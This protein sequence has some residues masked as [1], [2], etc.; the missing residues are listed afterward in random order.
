[1]LMLPIMP[2]ACTVQAAQS[3]QNELV[4]LLSMFHRCSTSTMGVTTLVLFLIL[5]A[6]CN[7]HS[8]ERV[9]YVDSSSHT[10]IDHSSCWEGGYSTPCLSLNLALKGAQHY[11]HSITILLQPGQH[12]LHNGSETQ[13]RNMSLLAIVGDTSSEGEV[14][15]KCQP[16][17]G[18]L[19]FR[20]NSIT[21]KN[22][23]MVCCGAL[24]NSIIKHSEDKMQSGV[25]VDTCNNIQLINV[26]VID[27]NGTGIVLYNPSGVVHLDMCNFINNSLSSV[28]PPAIGGGGLVIEADDVTTIFNC[29]I[30]NSNFTN[31]TY[32]AKNCQS[33]SPSEYL[34]L[35]GGISLLFKGG[36]ATNIITF[37]ELWL[38]NNMA[39]FGGGLFLVFY[40]SSSS[41]TVAVDNLMMIDNT[42][43]LEV[44]VLLPFASGGGIFLDFAASQVDYPYNNKIEI[45]NVKFLSNTAQLGGGIAVDV[46]YD[47]YGCVNAD[48]KLLIEN[49]SFDNNEGYQGASAYFSGTSKDCQ[50]LLNITISF[51]NFT[52]GNCSVHVLHTLPCLGSVLL[53]HFPLTLNGNSF[54]SG[55]AQ[56]AL[57]LTSSSIELI[58]SAQLQFTNNSGFNGAALHIADCS[59][60]IVNDNTS[61]YFENNQATHHG[62]A[63]Y[64]EACTQTKACFVRHSNS[65]LDPDQWKAKFTFINNQ[66]NI[67]GNSIYI[68]SVQSCVWPKYSKNVTFCWNEWQ[69][70]SHLDQLGSGPASITNN[71]PTKH[72]VYPGECINLHGFTVFDDFD[73]NITAQTNLQV[74]ILSGSSYAVSYNEPDCKCI[75]SIPPGSCYSMLNYTNRPCEHGEVAIRSDCEIDYASHGSQILIHPPHQSYGIVLDL[76]YKACDNGST[77]VN[78]SDYPGLCFKSSSP[79]LSYEGVCNKTININTFSR[80]CYSR[81][82]CGSCVAD[83]DHDV[84]MTINVPMFTCV[85]CENASG[86]GYFLIQILL[87][88]IMMTIL[89]VLHINITNG[90]LNAYILYSQMVTLQF[91]GLE[92]TAW[93]RTVDIICFTFLLD[94]YKYITI[95]LTVYSIW[96]INFLTF[97]PDSFC[98][99]GIRT[100]VGVILLQYVTAACPL[101]FIIVSYTWI[102]CYN[103]GYRL[104]VYTTG[105]VHRLLAR[106]WQKF[107]IKPSLIDTYAG[108][109]L[110][111]YMRFLAGSVKLLMLITFDS[112]F[113]SSQVAP[114]PLVIIPILCL[115]VFVILPMVVLLLYP[116]KIF[117]RCLTCCRLD[118]PGLHALVD[119]YQGCFKNSATDGT[120]RRYFAGFYLLFRFSYIAVVLVFS[121]SIAHSLTQQDQL[122]VMVLPLSGASLSFVMAGL[123]LILRPYKKTIHNIIDFLTLFLMTMFAALSAAWIS[124][125][126]IFSSI[127]ITFCFSLFYLPFLCLVV[128]LIYHMLICCGCCACVTQNAFRKSSHNPSKSSEQQPLLVPPT[129]HTVVGLGDY[130]EDDDYPDRMVHPD[131]YI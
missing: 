13:L 50:A 121:I 33:V 23:K 97:F 52:N 103:N 4:T 108:L 28:D 109:L 89:A 27:S 30:T 41:N 122:F 117:Q 84:G 62:G 31:N 87:V 101:L 113:A 46:V 40:D 12:Q 76:H 73:N 128:Y 22:L 80:F 47:G 100:A 7:V 37:S 130:A 125:S 116:F 88:M 60:V 96:N 51:S 49:C 106:F 19:F 53:N 24:H 110:L 71:G 70:D 129:T 114:V 102:Q 67:L 48:N 124:S 17:A 131:G 8:T 34:G 42:A 85:S 78:N 68:D 115:L 98:I 120:E 2:S 86:V 123:V 9:I 92:Y 79:I 20:S 90:N 39:P 36:S 81:I 10:G 94:G 56:S 82:K 16:L 1:M 32:T 63:I 58:P 29:S 57:G 69:Y 83:D 25:F 105:P 111:A 45:S 44:G 18:L 91:P 35:G 26:D 107:K 119:A 66:A 61:L 127:F 14:V 64:S 21:M 11:N 104:V 95:P 59:S 118:R 72:T 15:I 75:Y 65:T 99:P 6:S 38:V 77:C 126:I 93:T 43:L 55:N 74:D 112:K 3:I 54:F 5:A